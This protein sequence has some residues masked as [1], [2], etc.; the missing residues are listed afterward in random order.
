MELDRILTSV[1]INKLASVVTS[2]EHLHKLVV[3]TK[4]IE[5]MEAIQIASNVVQELSELLEAVRPPILN[6]DEFRRKKR[7]R[8]T[9]EK[10]LRDLR[11]Y[12]RKN[13]DWENWERCLELK[14]WSRYLRDLLIALR[15]RQHAR[16]EGV[17]KITPKKIPRILHKLEQ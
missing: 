9:H 16:P 3:P 5:V 1:P 17:T 15:L 12:C 4:E 14:K 7:K 11:I 13:E 6:K 8:V 10:T 2:Q